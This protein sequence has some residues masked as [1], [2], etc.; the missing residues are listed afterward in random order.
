MGL[1][2]D[3][4]RAAFVYEA[5]RAYAMFCGCPVVPRPW[6]LREED[7]KKGFV[8][9]V[10]ALCSGEM[11]VE[12]SPKEIHDQWVLSYKKMGWVYGEVYDTVKRVH[13]DL[14]PYDDLDPREKMKDDVFVKLV[15]LARSCF[16]PCGQHLLKSRTSENISRDELVYYQ[17]RYAEYD[18][19]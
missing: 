12:A 1:T 11:E 9:K 10:S 7:F 14:V 17:D 19:L 3:E 4:R 2:F 6:A 8:E 5:A 15:E 13:P 18:N 16:K